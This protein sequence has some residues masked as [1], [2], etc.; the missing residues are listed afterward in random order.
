MEIAVSGST[1]LI[2]SE[3]VRILRAKGHKVRRLVRSENELGTENILWHTR[4]GIRDLHRLEGIDAVV[5]LAG[6]S[7]AAGRWTARREKGIYESRVE[8]TRLL[9]DRIGRLQKRPGVFVSASA[10]G[11]YG[12][13]GDELL[14]ETSSPGEGF[15]SELAQAWE[16]E[17]SRARDKGMRLVC[18]RFG[19]V[20]ARSG[21]A[22]AKM[23]PVFRLGLGGK[24]GGGKQWMSW[25]ALS[26]LV[27]AIVHVLEKAELQGP[28]NVVAPAPVQ[29]E[30][31]SK[32]LGKVLRRPVLLPVP[33]VALKILMGQMANELLLSSQ[34]VMP[35]ELER[36]GFQFT[37][38]ELEGALSEI[39]KPPAY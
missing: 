12:D 10:I 6:A 16:S 3:L 36:T 19:I 2:G 25:I 1:G 22:L 21:G 5:N 7:I 24:L 9:V 26:D 38:P 4:Q 20:L 31:F 18:T 14:D 37:H 8:G 30:L 33:G 11:Y 39:L 32:V 29:M 35:R 27:Q 17:A 34:R 15:L 28:V 23:L 13:R